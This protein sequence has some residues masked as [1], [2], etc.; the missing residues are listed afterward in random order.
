MCLQ[1]FNQ[2]KNNHQQKALN[3]LGL[4]NIYMNITVKIAGLLSAGNWRGHTLLAIANAGADAMKPV[5][6]ASAGHQLSYLFF[7]IE[8]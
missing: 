7:I 4:A 5:K 6:T 8:Y 2:S 3:R 1:T